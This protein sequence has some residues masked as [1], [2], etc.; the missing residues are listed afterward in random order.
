MKCVPA[1]DST[2]TKITWSIVLLNFGSS[3]LARWFIISYECGPIKCHILN[4]KSR[5]IYIY[6]VCLIWSDCISCRML[7]FVQSV[8]QHYLGLSHPLNFII[9]YSFCKGLV[10]RFFQNWSNPIIT[11]SILFETSLWW[12]SERFHQKSL[13]DH[14]TR[15]YLVISRSHGMLMKQFMRFSLYDQDFVYISVRRLH[16]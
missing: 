9:D 7:W 12:C 8:S 10:D 13:Q 3:V 16:V 14:A 4:R 15:T 2:N 6:N 1:A 11:R 5:F